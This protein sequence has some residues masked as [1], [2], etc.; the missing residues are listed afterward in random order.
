MSIEAAFFGT[1]SRDAESK[2]SGAGKPYLRIVGVR[3]GDGDKAQWVSVTAFDQD[4]IAS[5]AKFLKGAPVYV[6]GRITLDKW[7]S[8]T[9]EDR[10]GLSCM[11]FHCRLAQIGRH[12]SKRTRQAGAPS[13]AAGSANFGGGASQAG[14]GDLDDE[15]PF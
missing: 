3:V 1:L 13:V 6:E 5:A 4:A 12:K 7:K 9:G 2:H 14:P 8:A 11:S 10:S 15:I